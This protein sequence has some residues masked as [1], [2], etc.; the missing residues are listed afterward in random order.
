MHPD[1]IV[2]PSE[3]YLLLPERRPAFVLVVV[4]GSCTCSRT[5]WKRAEVEG[6]VTARGSRSDQATAPMQGHRR[7]SRRHLHLHRV[8]CR[9]RAFCPASNIRRHGSPQ[10]LQTTSDDLPLVP[11]PGARRQPTRISF[12][13]GKPPQKKEDTIAPWERFTNSARAVFETRFL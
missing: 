10:P 5:Q 12:V 9:V 8:Q 2:R 3:S 11:C 7:G 4:N 1:S 6:R 13:D